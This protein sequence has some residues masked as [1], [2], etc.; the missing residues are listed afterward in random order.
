MS[1]TSF[2]INQDIWKTIPEIIKM[3]KHTDVAVAFLGID[4][5]KILPLKKGDR[6]IVDM[7]PATVKA[8]AT[9]PFEIEKLIKRG[10]KV[11]TRRN[12]H[13]KVVLTDKSVLVGS[14][15]VSKNSRDMLDEAA[16]FSTDALAVKR[17]RDFIERI[18][19]EPVLPKYL[20]E[21]QK[22]YRPPRTAGGNITKSTSYQKRASHAKLWIVSLQVASIPNKE[23]DK[24]ESSEKVAVKRINPETSVLENFHWAFRPK[25]TDELESGDLIIQ[26]VLQEDKSVLV[27]SPSRL[28]LIDHYIR[29]EATR[30]ERYVFHLEVS[31]GSQVMD[32]VRFR[33]ELNAITYKN[34]KKPRTMAIRDTTQADE[35][36]RLWTPKG[37]KARKTK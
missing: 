19:I 1:K 24:Y 13:A 23:L 36:L 28:I 9:N 8:G 2:L 35:L 27:Y 17:S 5:S 37:R 31:K 3:S 7:S 12:L 6:L 16:I 32:W 29:N 34:L 33:K 25:M 11:F 14:A 18:C 10:V 20:E 4:G 22:L 30:K 15:N 21:C 26:C